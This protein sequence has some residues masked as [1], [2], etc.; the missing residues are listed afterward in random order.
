MSTVTI[1]G[2]MFLGFY[3]ERKTVGSIPEE[4]SIGKKIARFIIGVIST[5]VIVVL[6]SLIP[7]PE[8][9]TFF[10]IYFMI[11]LWSIYIYPLIAVKTR[12]ME[13]VL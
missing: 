3:L 11:G 8:A 2:S 13:A 5:L 12:L 10:A 4:G 1:T 9:F 7:A 6:I